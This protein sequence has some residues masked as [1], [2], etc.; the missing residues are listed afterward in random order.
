MR[1]WNLGII[2]AKFDCNTDDC[3]A[4]AAQGGG[5]GLETETNWTLKVAPGPWHLERYQY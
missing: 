4:M 5:T 2:S 1:F 3:T